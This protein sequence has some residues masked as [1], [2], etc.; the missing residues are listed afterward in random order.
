MDPFNVLDSDFPNQL[1]LFWCGWSDLG[2]YFRSN[3]FLSLNVVLGFKG[4]KL[5]T[6][7]FFLF[8]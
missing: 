6:N 2:L 5:I 4:V 8:V 7:A 1:W 3:L